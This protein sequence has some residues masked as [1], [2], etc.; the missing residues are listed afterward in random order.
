MIDS[1]VMHGGTQLCLWLTRLSCMVVR[2]CA[3]DWLICHAWWYTTV[4]ITIIVCVC[5]WRWCHQSTR[6]CLRCLMIMNC[7]QQ[8]HH[9]HTQP[10]ML[11]TRHTIT[12]QQSFSWQLHSHSRW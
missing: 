10:L 3:Y 7:H 11:T 9:H 4:V 6:T 1:Y 2:N 5:V 12:A 8:S